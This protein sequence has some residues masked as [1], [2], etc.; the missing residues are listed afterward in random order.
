MVFTIIR[1]N[2]IISIPEEIWEECI[3][4]SLGDMNVF[5]S[6]AEGEA[7]AKLLPAVKE[8]AESTA[9]SPVQTRGPPEGKASRNF[10]N[11][12]N[13][14]K[15]YKNFGWVRANDI[16]SA[17]YWKNFTENFAQ[18]VT[19]LQKYPKSKLG[20]FMI[21]V[22]DVNETS[23]IA[24]VIVFAKGTIESPIITKILQIYEYDEKKLD[25]YRRNVYDLERRG[26]QPQV[27]E[28]FELYRNT[29]FG[30][31]VKF[32]TISG[33]NARDNEQLGT[34][35]G[36]GSGATFET[37]GEQFSREVITEFN[38]PEEAKESG[39]AAHE[40]GKASRETFSNDKNKANTESGGHYG[41]KG[42]Q[43]SELLERGEISAAYRSEDDIWKHSKNTRM[44][45]SLLGLT[46][47]QLRNNNIKAGDTGW[48][49][50]YQG[51]NGFGEPDDKQ[52]ARRFL[53][54]VHRKLSRT[55]LKN[56]DTVERKLSSYVLENFSETV[57]KTEDGRILSLWHWTNKKFS[58]FRYGDIGFHAGT[59]DASYAIMFDKSQK[60]ETGIFKELYF[61]SKNPLFIDRDLTKWTPYLVAVVS[62][63]LSE[64]EIAEIYSL[65]GAARQQYDSEAAIRVREM[66]KAKGY[67]SIIYT[68]DWEGGLSVIAFDAE[69][70]YTVA[71]NGVDVEGHASRELDAIDAMDE[72][73]E[74][75][76]RGRMGV[77]PLSDREILAGA[78]EGAAVNDIERNKLAEYRA[79]ID[80]M[81]AESAKLAELKKEIKELTFGK[82]KKDP[83]RLKALKSEATKTEN[84]INV[85]DK[86]LLGLETASVLKDVLERE[87]KKAYS[88]AAQKGRE[89]MHRNVEGRRKT[90]M[91]QY[92]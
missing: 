16:I 86:K 30:D 87:K 66:L 81:N 11:E 64:S 60:G 20:E 18:A 79:S 57:F 84:R 17:G 43:N 90:E 74:R 23:G 28:L 6:L 76:G 4:D 85:Y 49:E 61:N 42:S 13:S 48:L 69:Q 53:Q 34:D 38:S 67:D 32:K 89:A 8:A 35:R 39:N 88:R 70:F 24:D 10:G 29:D 33:E 83:E 71:E 45:K 68:N 63:V 62:N 25:K 21:A 92:I 55:K 77:E 58:Q 9:K 40:H 72:L 65:D 47:E 73:A 59:F 91:R 31:Y 80:R 54:G 27:G 22:Y 75:E 26:I 1:W 3:C 52:K 56:V 37:E 7:M 2:A 44:L 15:D 12:I 46:D 50:S 5:S 36:A 82:G 78:L 14:E 41:E 19:K 51:S